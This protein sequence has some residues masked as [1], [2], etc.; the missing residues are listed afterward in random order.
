MTDT[1]WNA[2][3]VKQEYSLTDEHAELIARTYSERDDFEQSLKS[4]E[5]EYNTTRKDAVS[6][7]VRWAV[8]DEETKDIDQKV[9]DENNRLT[10]ANVQ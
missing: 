9:W 1:N 5:S 10:G 6:T 2:Q 4:F 3:T 7:L 8:T